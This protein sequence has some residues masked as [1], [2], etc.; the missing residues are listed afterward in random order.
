MEQKFT[1]D[2]TKHAFGMTSPATCTRSIAR[3]CRPGRT[4]STWPASILGQQLCAARR[5]A[6][7]R[8]AR[9]RGRWLPGGKHGESWQHYDPLVLDMS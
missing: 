3:P 7:S 1:R 2:V 9:W 6:V 4:R 8:P 5:T